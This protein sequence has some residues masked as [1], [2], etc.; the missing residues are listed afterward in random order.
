MGLF[1]HRFSVRFLALKETGISKNEK[2]INIHQFK[3]QKSN[4][5]AYLEFLVLIYMLLCSN[6]MDLSAL[7]LLSSVRNL[8]KDFNRSAALR[9]SQNAVSPELRFWHILLR[10]SQSRLNTGIPI[11]FAKQR[12][13]F[14][15]GIRN[16]NHTTLR[17][18]QLVFSLVSVRHEFST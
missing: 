5:N 4:G 15:I 9:A 17:S 3:R 16:Y 13:K 11:A 8:G 10:Q 1:K 18:L 2:G 6:F 14:F 7:V 12:K